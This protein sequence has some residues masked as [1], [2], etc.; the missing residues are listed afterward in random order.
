MVRTS[1]DVKTMNADQVVAHYKSLS[2]VER[3]FRSLKTVDLQLRPI[4][5]HKDDRI[6]GHVFICMLA[7]YVE[8]HMRQPLRE[9]LFD[10]CDPHTACAP[11]RSAVD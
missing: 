10:D 6:R 5:H 9:V 8:W 1:V 2:R 4:D 3:A 11:R 7:Y